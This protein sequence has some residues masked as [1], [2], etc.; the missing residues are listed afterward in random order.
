MAESNEKNQLMEALQLQRHVE[1]GFYRRTYASKTTF[2]RA[3]DNKERP[4]MTTIFYMITDSHRGPYMVENASDLMRFFHMG[5]PV[6]IYMVDQEGKLTTTVMGT[7]FENGQVLQLL[8]KGGSW[9]GAVL[10]EGEYCLLSEAVAPGFDYEDMRMIRRDEVQ[11]KFP[12]L[13][14]RIAHLLIE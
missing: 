11:Q 2:Q 14:D 3:E 8:F 12:H 13:V 7:D 9:A 6:A 10:E 4:L 5:S 1:G